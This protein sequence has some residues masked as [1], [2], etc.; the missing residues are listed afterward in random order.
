MIKIILKD[1]LVKEF[2]FGLFVYD[3]VKLISEGLVR[4]VCCGIVNGIVCDFRKEINEDVELSICIF[5]F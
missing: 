5:D 4:N 1:G 3:I 2:E